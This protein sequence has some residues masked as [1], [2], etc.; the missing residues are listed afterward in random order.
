MK[1]RCSIAGMV[2]VL[3]CL[4]LY[5]SAPVY[6]DSRVR[7][8]VNGD[9]VVN[10]LDALQTVNIVLRGEVDHSQDELW[11]ADCNGD[12]GI[13]IIDALGVINVILEVGIC[14]SSCDDLDCDDGNS[15]TDD[16]C[17]SALVRCFNDPLP[18]GISCDDGDPCTIND[19]CVNGNC[20]GT[21]KICDDGDPC[22][23]DFCNPHTGQC[24]SAPRNCDDGDPC[25][26][27]SCNPVTGRCE[28]VPV[29][30]D[31][32]DPCTDDF[33]NSATGE[34]EHVFICNTPPTALFTVDP[35]SG[36]TETPFSVDASGSTD[37]QDPTSTLEVRWDWESNGTYDTSWST[38]KRASHQY[39]IPGTKTITL[40]VMDSEGLT[41]TETHQ[42]TVDITLKDIDGN[43]YKTVTIGTQIWM[44][45]NLMVTRY[46]NG[47]AIP[48]VTENSEWGDL[49]T[50]AYCNYEE[51]SN[52]V[53]TYGRLYNWY[54]VIDDRNIAPEGWHVA[55]DDDLKQLE[56][57][58]G[59]SREEADDYGWRGTNEGGKLKESGTLHW[60]NPN[61][62][63]TNESGFSA[64]PG[65]HR[66]DD[67]GF[68]GM[69]NLAFF[70][71][72]T[73]RSNYYAWSRT[74]VFDKAEIRRLYYHT[75]SGFSVRCVKD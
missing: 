48:H 69:G 55:T 19:R 46:R 21:P 59:M 64:L 10:I 27:D 32:G 60:A 37:E 71:S 61:L 34:C 30:C 42:V 40:E 14:I 54:A 51:N 49:T 20:V 31:D 28:F 56:M 26:D 33:C 7:G 44:A 52:S 35:L 50:G 29:S 63:A 66:D 6:G 45:E 58:L 18:P 43:M 75:G 41:D 70:W 16:Y 2:I 3:F 62:G 24:E 4:V 8:D 17:D 53:A 74:L 12:G 11:A 72:S 47:D 23:D 57:Y 25:T 73:V 5:V 39:S 22:T 36:T 1:K 9:G 67:G 15:C 65:G 38:T 68:Y 13:N